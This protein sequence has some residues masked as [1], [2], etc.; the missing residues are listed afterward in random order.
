MGCVHYCQGA[1][2]VTTTVV[3]L[4][5]ALWESS[6]PRKSSTQLIVVSQIFDCL[7]MS[8]YK[9]DDIKTFWQTLWTFSLWTSSTLHVLGTYWK[10]SRYSLLEMCCRECPVVEDVRWLAYSICSCNAA[11]WHVMP[12]HQ[13]PFR[14]TYPPFWCL[15][16]EGCQAHYL[17]IPPPVYDFMMIDEQSFAL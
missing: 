1:V 9:P 2:E 16:E 7:R 14:L 15:R 4:W 8:L 11:E 17:C 3:C 6:C 13:A 5:N 12:L 10:P